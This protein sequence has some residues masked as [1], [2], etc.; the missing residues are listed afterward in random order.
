LPEGTYHVSIRFF[1]EN[2]EEIC[3]RNKTV[4]L[5]EAD[6]NPEPPSGGVDLELSLATDVIEFEQYEYINYTLTLENN[7]TVSAHDI[8]IDFELPEGTAYSSHIASA[9]NYSSWFGEWTIDQ[10]SA[11]QSVILQLKTF[12]VTE[13]ASVF[14][15]AQVAEVD[16]ADVDSTPGN[17]AT[18]VP[19]E[20]D[21]T[22]L[23]LQAHDR[24][25]HDQIQIALDQ[26][27]FLVLENI[28]PNPASNDLTLQVS[29]SV[30]SGLPIRIYNGA[31]EM[32]EA[33]SIE[34]VEGFNQVRLD[35]SGLPSGIYT[36]LFVGEYGH[37]PVRFV[38]VGL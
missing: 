14:A 13:E 22:A 18:G 3:A 23:A 36:I 17:N 6:D 4:D 11:G 31:G 12:V 27:R 32:K 15:F 9:G 5:T 38:K 10:L 34:L 30:N 35:I 1:N 21:E 25:D 24:S 7:G 33:Y 20:D 37:A 2:W 28:F 16:E 19:A 8:A 29:A 26:N